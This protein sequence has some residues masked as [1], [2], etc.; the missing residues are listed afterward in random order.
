[1]SISSSL[2]H[3]LH[4]RKLKVLKELL[5]LR[6][7]Y[8]CLFHTAPCPCLWFLAFRHLCGYHV[9]NPVIVLTYVFSPSHAFRC[10]FQCFLPLLVVAMSF[11]ATP[12]S[13]I[14]H[15]HC[16][17]VIPGRHWFCH[18]CPSLHWF[19]PRKCR[20]GFSRIHFA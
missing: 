12:S 5:S 19:R 9:I 15:H 10:I 8:F 3:C 7:N 18:S 2:C 20:A 4:Y 16:L 1:M 17:C 14:S 11:P 6:C 13:V